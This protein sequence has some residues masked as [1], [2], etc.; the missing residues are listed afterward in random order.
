MGS[1]STR[2]IHSTL[3]RARDP[4]GVR[5]LALSAVSKGAWYR[6]RWLTAHALRATSSGRPN[7]TSG[8]PR[9]AR[10]RPV[11]DSTAGDNTFK[12]RLHVL[13]WNCG[14][15]STGLLDELLLYLQEHASHVNVVCLQETHWKHDS[16]W[17]T[18]RWIC[19]HDHDPKHT[20]AGVLTLISRKLVSSED[21]RTISHVPGRMLQV[22]FPVAGVHAD[23]INC[24]QIPWTTRGGTQQ[25][26]LDKRAKLWS[27]LEAAVGQVP[28]RN[29]L[30]IMGDFNVQ[31]IPEAGRVGT[32][33]C[34]TEHAE[35]VA[36]DGPAFQ[37]LLQ[38][39]DLIAV[40]T[41]L[42]PRRTMRTYQQNNA[43]TQIDYIL[44]RTHSV[45]AVSKTSAP[46]GVF[47]VAA[48]RLD[49]NHRPVQAQ[50]SCHRHPWRLR[51]RCQPKVDVSRLR[52]DC[53]HNPIA[54]NAIKTV[55][56][57]AVQGH[58]S[59][60]DLNANVFRVV[61]AAYPMKATAKVDHRNTTAMVG[62]IRRMWELWREVRRP[63]A[64]SLRDVVR[65]WRLMS[66]LRAQRR[67]VQRVSRQ[68]RRARV[69]GLLDDAA[70]AAQVHDQAGLYKVVN[71]LGPKQRRVRLQL[72]DAQGGM[73]T[74]S[75]K[76]RS[77][78]SSTGISQR[79]IALRKSSA[80]HLQRC[81]NSM[82]LR[83]SGVYA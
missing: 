25:Q 74:K 9:R 73:L 14:G 47:P 2:E 50:F 71:R 17:L 68:S 21:I 41:F 63:R 27:A 42:G 55:V 52:A 76:S 5:V 15:L 40:N 20:Y 43:K 29:L 59:P 57:E 61:A 80:R 4:I 53:L 13:T 16:E 54:A 24:Y 1:Q 33:T 78:R 62:P 70:K 79:C 81:M 37:S 66:Q 39:G 10:A 31:L 8:A 38:A 67:Q 46:V 11:I 18:E 48:Y 82:L 7:P 69:E 23:V 36:T 3:E 34:V 77:C 30:C 75:P 32:A 58:P 65:K 28:H 45:D 22:R 64:A 6:G 19:V 72:R 56:S 49:C 35:Q 12:Q 51:P 60:E 83:S 26:L 44:A